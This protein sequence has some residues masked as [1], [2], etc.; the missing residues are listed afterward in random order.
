MLKL[1]T[2]KNKC[3]LNLSIALNKFIEDGWKDARNHYTRVIKGQKY[4]YIDIVK[5][6]LDK[7]SD[8]E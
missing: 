2:L 6:E 1:K 8:S 5:E 7:E 4:Y 3:E